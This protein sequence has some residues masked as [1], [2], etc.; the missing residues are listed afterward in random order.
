MVL[1]SEINLPP[2]VFQFDSLG[3]SEHLFWNVVIP[4]IIAETEGNARQQYNPILVGGRIL[5]T[6]KNKIN[7]GQYCISP[8]LQHG[9]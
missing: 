1:K 8:V 2:N 9:E 6:K 7:L 5:F 4:A 3:N